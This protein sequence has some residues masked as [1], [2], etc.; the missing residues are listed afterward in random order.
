MAVLMATGRPAPDGLM[1]RGR[2]DECVALDR[3][4]DQVRAGRRGTLVLRGEA[5]VGKTALLDYAVDSASDLTVIPASGVA[6]EMELAFAA[7]HQLCGPLLDRLD[8]LPGPQRH[9]LEITFGLSEGSAPDR[10]FVGLAVLG[11]LSEAAGERPL[12]CVIDDAQWLDRASA[13]AFTFVARRLEAESVAM[14]FAAREASGETAGLPELVLDGLRGPDARALLASVVPGRLDNRIADELLAETR[15]NPLALLELPRGLT[16]AQLAGGFGLP[17]ALSLP[18]RIE[19]S[20]RQRLAALPE[21]TQRL[22]LVAAADPTGDPALFWLAAEQLRIPGSA[23]EPAGSVGLIGLDSMVR[24]RHPLARSAVYRAAA[25]E[26]RRRAHRA[27]AEATDA[28]IDPDRRAWHLA[29]AA[30]GPDEE[31]AAELE[32]AAGRAQA[33]GGL[34]AAAPFLAR[35]AALTP[36]LSRRGQRALAAARTAYEAGALSDALALLRTAEES[37][38]EV[39]RCHVHLLRA[40]I[41]FASH[42]GSDA[43]PMLLE[44]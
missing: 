13:Q 26:D 1:L 30:T 2:K 5:G 15:G 18:R 32:Q 14:L 4:L 34:A 33:R 21:D 12:L 41:E 43:P 40:Q 29:Q 20:F 6:S 3:L 19:E 9:A 11:L 25:P 35:A 28:K 10:F 42:R 27:L 17:A 16:A 8:R 36:E 22:L 44:A 37:A 38:D 24:F 39:Q 7:L 23:L 31:V